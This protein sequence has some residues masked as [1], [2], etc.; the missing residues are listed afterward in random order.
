M[1]RAW[2]WFLKFG[3]ETFMTADDNTPCAIRIFG[4][5]FAIIASG[6]FFGLAIHTVY[7]LKTPLDY[8]GFAGGLAALWGTVAAAIGFKSYA[9]RTHPASG[10]CHPREDPP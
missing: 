8:G 6:V 3:R 7:G 1:N 10:N 2:Q 5:G 4:V 9:E